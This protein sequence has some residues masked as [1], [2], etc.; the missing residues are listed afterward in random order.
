MTTLAVVGGGLDDLQ[1]S[2]IELY[3]EISL[4]S[5]EDTPLKSI[6]S[7][8]PSKTVMLLEVP[9]FMIPRNILTYFG[10]SLEGF[11]SF[12]V[13]RYFKSHDKYTALIEMVSVEAA[14]QL[15][16]DYSGHPLSSLEPSCGVCKLHTV[17]SVTKRKS[18]G[19]DG[20][21]TTKIA[22]DTE[23]RCPLCLAPLPE[24]AGDPAHTGTF[25]TFCNHHFHIACIKHM[26]APQ[27]PVC[28][29]QH[30]SG[31]TS[32]SEC[33]S[34]GWKGREVAHMATHSTGVPTLE[35]EAAGDLWVCLVCGYV[36]CGR[37]HLQ[38]IQQHYMDQLHAYA[39]NV[40]TRQVWDFAGGG[41]VHRLI[42][43]DQQGGDDLGALKMSEVAN[44]AHT[45]GNVRSRS[46]LS[47]DQEDRMVSLKLEATAENYND[48]LTW[49][50][51][52]QRDLYEARLKLI[53]QQ[54]SG[55]T[56][57]RAGSRSFRQSVL[58]SLATE[59]DKV[60]KQ[61]DTILSRL[62]AA[63]EE[64]DVSR[65]LQASLIDSEKE[66]KAKVSQSSKDLTCMEKRYRETIPKLEKQVAELMGRMDT[67]DSNLEEEEK[68]RK[69]REKRRAATQDAGHIASSSST[70]RGFGQ[71]A[72]S[73]P[74]KPAAEDGP[75]NIM[76]PAA[77]TPTAVVA[78]MCRRIPSEYAALDELNKTHQFIPNSLQVRPTSD[79]KDFKAK[80]IERIEKNYVN[81][82]DYI[83]HSV[84]NCKTITNTDGQLTVANRHRA[85]VHREDR[86]VF[87]ANQFPYQNQGHHHVL[88]YSGT[89]QTHSDEAISEHIRAELQVLTASV[90]SFDFAWYI[91]P[92][93]TVPEFFHV[94][95]FW[96]TL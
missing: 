3:D 69:M 17:K 47:S 78:K 59:A 68:E 62:K 40:D 82:V 61:N 23:D 95:V 34:C 67:I 86:R 56:N 27:C 79:M 88:W 90:A 74:D 5:S 42:L 4:E 63:K 46:E 53:Q 73:L 71:G 89:S 92:K 11:A 6:P 20:N 76:P 41:F 22:D 30:D 80:E 91:N 9:D 38:H 2:D 25:T 81:F 7:I 1:V 72:E 51:L 58:E 83:Y 84:F 24:P 21:L 64:L 96:T 15:V 70:R 19:G 50:L 94:Q 66:W 32:L 18:S 43:A 45:T 31:I 54:A 35:G 28:R 8:A 52:Q 93:M 37:S 85:A 39:M 48:L 65:S 26:E 87:V 44:P 12:R 49:Q 16:E 14:Q 77:P 75:A 60:R 55:T 29:F 57:R 36:G 10:G 33:D 13:M